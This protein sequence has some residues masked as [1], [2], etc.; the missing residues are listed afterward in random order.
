MRRL[1]WLFVF[2]LAGACSPIPMPQVPLVQSDAGSRCVR[3]CQALYNLCLGET[4]AYGAE[5]RPCGDDKRRAINA[6]RE[7]L[8]GCYGTC[9]P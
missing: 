9:P 5:P 2:A 7:N 8:G 1:T 6:C 4:A 3:N